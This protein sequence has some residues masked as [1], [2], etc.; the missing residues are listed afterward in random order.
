MIDRY[1]ISLRSKEDMRGLC[2][3]VL[4]FP[5]FFLSGL[6]HVAVNPVYVRPVARG[7]GHCSLLLVLLALHLHSAVMLLNHTSLSCAY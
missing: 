4:H 1:T 3:D 2:I 5:S 6:M 7:N